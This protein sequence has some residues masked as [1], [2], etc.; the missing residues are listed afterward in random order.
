PRPCRGGSPAAGTVCPAAAPSGAAAPPRPRRAAGSPRRTP[1]RSGR[2]SIRPSAG[3]LWWARGPPPPLRPCGTESGSP[4]LT[5]QRLGDAEVVRR[6]DL[7][8]VRR[9]GDHLDRE[10]GAL[11]QL[12]IVG[13]DGVLLPYAGVRFV[14]HRPRESLRRLRAPETLPR[15]GSRDTILLDDF[16]DRVVHQ[17]DA[18]TRRQGTQPRPHRLSPRGAAGDEAQAIPHELPQPLRRP[19]G[20]AGGHRHDHLAYRGVRRKGAERPEQHRYTVD[21]TELLRLTRSGA[22]AGTRGHDHYAD[23]RRRGGGRAHRS[24]PPRPRRGRRRCRASAPTGRRAGI[25]GGPLLRGAAPRPPPAGPPRPALPRPEIA[26][27]PATP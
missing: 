6:R 18:G 21:G 15:D 17:H 2:Q 11:A 12:R 3:G 1:F 19:L 27:L 22:D 4:Q 24:H 10:P 9:I 8:I 14:D 13:W 23:V 16:F 5:R 26:H 7:E 20:E 25:P